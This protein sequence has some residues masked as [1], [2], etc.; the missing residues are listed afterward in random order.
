[1]IPS[2]DSQARRVIIRSRFQRFW[3][4]RGSNSRSNCAMDVDFFILDL[5]TISTN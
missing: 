2:N 1:M 3:L 5:L 4:L